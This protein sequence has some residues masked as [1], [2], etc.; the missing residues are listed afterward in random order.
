MQ[1]EDEDIKFNHEM[2]IKKT[3]HETERMKVEDQYRREID[4]VRTALFEKKKREEYEKQ[5][6][7]NGP[8]LQDQA[9]LA[10][11]QPQQENVIDFDEKT[12]SKFKK[13]Q[14]KMEKIK[15][16][17]DTSYGNFPVSLKELLNDINNVCQGYKNLITEQ[18]RTMTKMVSD[19]QQQTSQLA[20]QFQTS[21]SDVENSYRAALNAYANGGVMTTMGGQFQLQ[22]PPIIQTEYA[23]SSSRRRYQNSDDSED[24]YP[25]NKKVKVVYQGQRRYKKYHED[26]E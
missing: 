23:R 1:I 7:H 5:S 17:F 22:S 18:N 24:D 19:F 21:L 3:K 10:Y 16:Q 6:M 4:Q 26:Y 2:E 13:L 15:T 20:R 9:R 11:Q 25:T 8:Y 12:M 14:Y